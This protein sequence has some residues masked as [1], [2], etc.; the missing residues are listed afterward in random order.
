MNSTAVYEYNVRSITSTHFM[1]SD[2]LVIKHRDSLF[3]AERETEATIEKEL[4]NQTQEKLRC[5]F[6]TEVK[7]LGHV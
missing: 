2:A 7:Y 6:F 1:R 4:S 3:P 5:F